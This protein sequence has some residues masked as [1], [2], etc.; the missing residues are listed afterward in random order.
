MDLDLARGSRNLIRGTEFREVRGARYFISELKLY[1]IIH[2]DE[3]WIDFSMDGSLPSLRVP[4]RV[5]Q[6]HSEY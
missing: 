4:I 6:H 5:Q 2:E 3:P 1:E